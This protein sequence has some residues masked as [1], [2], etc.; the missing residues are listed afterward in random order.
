MKRMPRER[1]MSHL[2]EQLNTVQLSPA[3]RARA[4]A[5]IAQAERIA[6]RIAG[7]ARAIDWVLEALIV[8]PA[9]RAFALIRR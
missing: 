3:D 4:E 1:L 5:S 8:R 9:R 2:Y 6:E 7:V